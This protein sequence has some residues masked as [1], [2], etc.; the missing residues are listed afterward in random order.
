L[1]EYFITIIFFF[2][3]FFLVNFKKKKK[4]KFFNLK[5]KI[6]AEVTA[7][8]FLFESWFSR[9]LERKKYITIL[10]CPAAENTPRGN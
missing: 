3:F 5:K 7:I 10:N 4:I 2:Y 1:W 8:T 9:K 6:V